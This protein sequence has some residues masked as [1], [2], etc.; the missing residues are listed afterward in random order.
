[1][2]VPAMISGRGPTRATSGEASPEATTTPTA[3]G[4]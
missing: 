3:N 1:M 2:A 4:R